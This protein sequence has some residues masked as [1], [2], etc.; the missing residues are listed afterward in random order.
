ML[1]FAAWA[2]V[3]VLAVMVA[4]FAESLM[5]WPQTAR[6][7]GAPFARPSRC[8]FTERSALGCWRPMRRTF[9][10]E[11]RRSTITPGGCF[12]SLRR[13]AIQAATTP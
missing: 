11:H 5:I 12:P 9:T 10:S 7:F 8:R 6:S 1:T 4:A 13:V 3:H 2:R